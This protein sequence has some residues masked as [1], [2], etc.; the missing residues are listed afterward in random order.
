VDVLETVYRGRQHYDRH[1]V[2]ED[3]HYHPS[4]EF[5][6]EGDDQG[7]DELEGEESIDGE[8]HDDF[9]APDLD[10]YAEEDEDESDGDYE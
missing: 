8:E 2:S 10:G 1:V 9:D 6:E 4:N 7:E 3:L 5:G